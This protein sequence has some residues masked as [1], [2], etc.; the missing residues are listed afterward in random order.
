[1]NLA[2]ERR[3]ISRSDDLR[4]FAHA[5]VNHKVENEVLDFGTPIFGMQNSLSPRD[6]KLF[7]PPF[8]E[9]IFL[10]GLEWLKHDTSERLDPMILGQPG[11]GKTYLRNY[12]A[13]R[14]VKEFAKVVIIFAKG[15][16][17]KYAKIPFHVIVVDNG[18]L[19]DCFTVSY[20]GETHLQSF[21]EKWRQAS[22]VIQCLLDVS[23]GYLNTLYLQN[24]EVY[25]RLLLFELSLY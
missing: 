7:V 4:R 10:E 1:M 24:G 17:E 21:V 20:E 9:D 15:Q 23:Y 12:I 3:Y 14:L 2:R 19:S 18:V 8:Y 11:T 6:T 22:F 13:H 25:P 16:G 5:C